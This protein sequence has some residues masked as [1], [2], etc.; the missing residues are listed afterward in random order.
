MGLLAL[1]KLHLARGSS[2]FN[3]EGAMVLLAEQDRSLWNQAVIAE[4]IALIEHAAALGRPGPYQLE[5]AIAACHARARTPEETDWARIVA[6]YGELA[7]LAPSGRRR[8][9][10]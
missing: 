1:M 5:A 2:R 4:G 10:G 6:L 3:R 7:N 9:V 8:S